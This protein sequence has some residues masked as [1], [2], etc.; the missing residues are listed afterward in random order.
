MSALLQTLAIQLDAL[1][2]RG[3]HNHLLADA[4]GWHWDPRPIGCQSPRSNR[5]ND[6]ST[7]FWQQKFSIIEL[8][9]EGGREQDAR[10]GRIRNGLNA[11][12]SESGRN[13]RE[14]SFAEAEHH[15]RAPQGGCFSPADR[16]GCHR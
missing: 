15:L 4:D 16:P 6:A 12:E 14:G 9:H 7:A 8:I 5:D 10:V 3:T 13:K 11:Q 2:L 1:A